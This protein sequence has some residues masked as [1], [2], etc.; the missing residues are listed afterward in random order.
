M[1]SES[2]FKVALLEGQCGKAIKGPFVCAVFIDIRTDF[3]SHK[4]K[5][6][7]SIFVEWLFPAYLVSFDPFF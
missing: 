1:L 6:I 4:E 7:L 3:S 5:S 2:F